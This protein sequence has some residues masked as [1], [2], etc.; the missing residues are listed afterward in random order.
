MELININL[1]HLIEEKERIISNIK[2]A[3]EDVSKANYTL[4]KEE[5]RLWTDTPFKDLGFTNKDSRR[6]FV[7]RNLVEY[8]L[9][10]EQKR[11][12]LRGLHRDLDLCN[13]K[14]KLFS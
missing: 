14:I 4:K 8:K 11:N 12:V 7:Q 2:N 5:T 3:E 6:A 10:Y 1:K 13:D 9:D